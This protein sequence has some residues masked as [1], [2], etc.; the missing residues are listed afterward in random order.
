[1]ELNGT[2]NMLL[3]IQMVKTIYS[4]QYLYKYNKELKIK[5]KTKTNEPIEKE[6]VGGANK[7]EIETNEIEE[8]I[9]IDK[10]TNIN[11]DS[12]SNIDEYDIDELEKISKEDVIINKDVD[13]I[14]KSLNLII[15]KTDLEQK[16]DKYGKIV[17]WNEQ[18]DN[19]TVDEVLINIYNKIYIYNQYILKDDTIKTIKNKIC[20]G[21]EKSKQIN[22]S[23][24][25]FLPSRLYLWSEYNYIENEK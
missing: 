3:V 2:K 25:Y 10:L 9:E 24:P 20:C 16:N 19:N 23:S 13:N 1:M 11:P 4:Y 6:M 8:T 12:E 15:D 21:Y 17:K 7:E 22:K 18:K 5:A 14:N